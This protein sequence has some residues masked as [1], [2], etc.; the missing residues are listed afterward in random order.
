MTPVLLNRKEAAAVLRISTQALGL[1]TKTSQISAVYLGS[2]V[3]Y[4]ERELNAFIKAQ[5]KCPKGCRG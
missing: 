3:L 1:Y 5:K 2:R 4:E